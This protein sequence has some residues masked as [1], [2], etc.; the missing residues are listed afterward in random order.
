MNADFI[1]PDWLIVLMGENINNSVL[2]LYSVKLQEEM[3]KLLNFFPESEKIITLPFWMSARK[4]EI[5]TDVAGKR[6]L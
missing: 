2:S 1:K 3:I 5:F 4:N 6:P